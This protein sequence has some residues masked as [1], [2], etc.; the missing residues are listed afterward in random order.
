MPALPILLQAAA[1]MM[2]PGVSR[3]LADYRAARVADVRYEL[4]LDVTAADTATGHVTV[5]FRRTGPGGGG[6][7]ILD[8]RG[9]RLANVRANGA[10]LDGTPGYEANGAHVRVP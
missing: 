10:A 7:A 4:R 2:G 6:D 1:T 5:R 3:E 9:P 8:F